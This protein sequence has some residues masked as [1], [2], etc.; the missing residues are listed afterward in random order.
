MREHKET[1]KHLPSEAAFIYDAFLLIANT[2]DKNN[3]SKMIHLSL[4][5]S[6]SCQTE[7]QWFYGLQFMKYLKT[8]KINGLSGH[9]EF[10]I[11]SG[12]RTNLKFSIVDRT[13]DSVELVSLNKLINNKLFF[14][15]LFINNYKIGYWRDEPVQSQNNT[16]QMVRSFAKERDTVYSRLNRKLFVTTK[17]EEPYVM[18]NIPLNNQI[19]VGNEKYR[20]YC[21]DLLDKI[22]KL[23]NFTYTIKLVEDGFLV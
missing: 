4:S 15:S 21:V 5:K 18:E 16:I 22:S 19:L 13:D 9:I 14:F 11:K 23:C 2:I 3:L 20:G 8:N 6:V 1:I 17:L 12:Y 10:D 7:N